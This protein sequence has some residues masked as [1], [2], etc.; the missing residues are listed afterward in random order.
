MIICK[1]WDPF[2]FLITYTI[3]SC[4]HFIHASFINLVTTT[5]LHCCPLYIRYLCAHFLP[6]S[7]QLQQI[8]HCCTAVLLTTVSQVFTWSLCPCKLLQSCQYRTAATLTAIC[9]VFTRSLHIH[10]VPIVLILFPPHYCIAHR[11]KCFV[12]AK[13]KIQDENSEPDIGKMHYDM[14]FII[15]QPGNLCNHINVIY[16]SIIYILDYLF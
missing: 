12:L 10:S 6:N 7:Y 1:Y 16:N 2:T 9:Q 15:T 5:P 11:Y 8:C 3:Y 13:K 4:A 14:V